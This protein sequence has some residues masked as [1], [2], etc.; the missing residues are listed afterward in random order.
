[1][2]GRAYPVP[3]DRPVTAASGKRSP[4]SHWRAVCEDFGVCWSAEAI[5]IG[6][7]TYSGTRA[8]HSGND[9]A[10]GV[11]AHRFEHA[12][13]LPATPILTSSLRDDVDRMVDDG[14][15]KIRLVAEEQSEAKTASMLEQGAVKLRDVRYF[16]EKMAMEGYFALG[17]S[18][19]EG[20]SPELTP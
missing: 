18:R 15:V 10:V 20:N 9:D 1:M 11:I 12:R 4:R 3:K 8:N 13:T 16:G 19:T 6:G 14:E 5:F 7:A 17:V 2:T